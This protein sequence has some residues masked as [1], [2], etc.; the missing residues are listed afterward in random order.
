MKEV[1]EGQ[2]VP[3]F[4]SRYFRADFAYGLRA[5]Q[6][7]AHLCGVACPHI[8]EVMGWYEDVSENHGELRLTW[9][10]MDEMVRAYTQER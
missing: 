10:S 7:I 9:S 5:I 6:G 4:A 3:D 2:W 8:D 1:A